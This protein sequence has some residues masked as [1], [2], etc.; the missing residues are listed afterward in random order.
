MTMTKAKPK[1]QRDDYVW[2]AFL[3]GET[4]CD[5]YRSKK[6]KI[7]GEALVAL[8]KNL[9]RGKRYDESSNLFKQLRLVSNA[10]AKVFSKQNRGYEADAE[11]DVLHEESIKA[12]T[13]ILE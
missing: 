6:K 12:G 2:A 13:L 1:W 11:I 4:L 8:S 3:A 9:K 7:A 5:N 10:S